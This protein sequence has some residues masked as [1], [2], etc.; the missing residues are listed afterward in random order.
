MFDTHAPDEAVGAQSA[1][2]R[3]SD[4]CVTESASVTNVAASKSDAFPIS[5]SAVERRFTRAGVPSVQSAHAS[6]RG[7][8]FLAAR[9]RIGKRGCRDA[10]RVCRNHYVAVDERGAVRGGVPL[11]EQRGWLG[12]A[13]I[14]LINIHS[15]LSEGI[16]DR[17]FSGVSLQML[18]FV[19]GRSRFAYAVGMGNA[20]NA[21]PRLLRAAGWS[22]SPVPFQFAVIDPLSERDRSTAPWQ[23]KVGGAGHRRLGLGLGAAQDLAPGSSRS[24][25]EALF[26]RPGDILARR[27]RCGL[28]AVLRRGQLLGVARRTDFGGSLPR[29]RAT[30]KRF[31]LRSGGE[32]VGW[33][34]SVATK[35]KQDPNFGD[36]LVGTILDGLATKAHVGVLLALTRK[37]L[38]EMG[39]EVVHQPDTSRLGRRVASPRVREGSFELSAGHVE[40]SGGQR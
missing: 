40:G 25:R 6:S 13:V 3:L 27:D 11:M 38:R 10:W 20:E 21:F 26:S 22:M 33:S 16:V 18:K 32:V 9:R 36:M 12:S 4:E 34:V 28:G 29:Q 17:S 15:P 7:A 1:P 31:L 30:V 2:E 37:A 39:A 14:P 19:Y 24:F 23:P 5:E 8:A 35:M